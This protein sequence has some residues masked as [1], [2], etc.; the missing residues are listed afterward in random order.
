VAEHLFYQLVEYL[1]ERKEIT[2]EHLFVDGTKIEANANRYSFV[3]GKSV[4]KR[5]EKLQAKLNAL[6]EEIRT[7][8]PFETG[9]S[10]EPT[11]VL[12]AL[13]K[14]QKQRG[15]EAVHGK[16]KRKGALQRHI[17]ALGAILTK[18]EEY[19]KH[20]EIL[21][22]RP[23][24]SKTDH[25][26]T[27]MRMK[28][29]HMGNGQLKPAYNVQLGVEAEY[30]VCVDVGSERNDLYSLLPL[31]QRIEEG[32]GIRHKAIVAD[33]GY[34]S[35]ENYTGLSGRGQAAYIKPQNY[36]KS[37]RRSFCRNAF[38][39]EHMPYDER[40]DA[41]T[42]PAGKKLVRRGEHIRK[43]KSGFEQTVTR[44]ACEGC[45]GCVLKPKCTKAQET[46]VVEVSKRFVQQRGASLARITSE[47]GILLR[48]NRSIQSEGAFGVLKEDW[49]F[50]RFLRRGQTNVMTEL[51]IYGFAF[52]V[53]KLHVKAMR[54]RLGMQLIQ[55]DSA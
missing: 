19:R 34:E 10:K 6:L 12:A 44:Y 18:Q 49:G 52:D 40:E 32:C 20:R 42:C 26:S 43:S 46:R 14:L 24:Y 38:L 31:L 50:R 23:S 30:I 11:E 5:A 4:G 39:R 36:E 35:E 53:C 17:E 25:D 51:L 22:N 48:V 28:E 47:R 8:Y 21:G 7:A 41:Y 45:V 33:A 1:R 16:G 29:D 27:F 54:G 15:E 37:K 13:E 55:P 2:G 9:W 3:W